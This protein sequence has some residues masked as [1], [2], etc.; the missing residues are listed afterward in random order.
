MIADFV[1]LDFETANHE[2]SSACSIGI[3][4]VKDLCITEK[5]YSLIRPK[6]M[7][8]EAGNIRIHGITPEMVETAPTLDEIWPEIC[9]FF[10][11]HIPVVAHNAGFD[12][13]V[14]KCSVGLDLPDFYYVDTIRMVSPIIEGSKS[15]EHCAECMGIPVVHHHN[16]L[17]DASTCAQ[18]AVF[19]LGRA[20][21]ATLW[22]YLAKHG[23]SIS[24]HRISD[25]NPAK[26]IDAR[27][28]ERRGLAVK[29]SLGDIHCE[30]EEIDS[31]APLFNSN[32]V[33]TG[34]LSISRRDA[35][36]IAVNCGATVRTSVSKKTNY[37]VVG[38]QDKALVGED[39]MST[40]EETAYSLNADGKAS[41]KIIGEDEFLQLAGVNIKA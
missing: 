38:K 14:L 35:M 18:I 25:L 36:Q 30:A 11:A 6:S 26:S 10:S 7:R 40:K 33:F 17:D 34:E 39:G 37:L 3:V 8:F 4:A 41:I 9:R 27:K 22:E 31:N 5:F 13:S 28:K 19:V 21:C 15:L 2:R 29:I 20:G 1:A 12:M 32:V 23:D 24:A 16:A